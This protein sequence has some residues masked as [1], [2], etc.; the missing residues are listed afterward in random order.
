MRG[1]TGFHAQASYLS[2]EPQHHRFWTILAF[3]KYLPRRFD[4]TL[5][6]A[7]PAP[8]NADYKLVI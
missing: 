2:G 6:R 5:I 8:N 7:L 1:V 4:G 3:D